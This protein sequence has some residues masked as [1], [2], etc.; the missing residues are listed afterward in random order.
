MFA[1][2]PALFASG[3]PHVCS[4]GP[5]WVADTAPAAATMTA[6]AWGL[7]GGA[8]GTWVIIN[9]ATA[10]VYVSTDNGANFVTATSG[11]FGTIRRAIAYGNS[12]FLMANGNTDA[13]TSPDGL[14]WTVHP[15][16]VFGCSLLKF[17]PLF[18]L[19]FQV[20][21]FDGSIYST[22][23]GITFTP[24]ANPMSS[25]A[26]GAMAVTS[27][28][29][30]LVTTDQQSCSTVNGSTWLAGGALPFATVGDNNSAM[31]FG[32]GALVIA[33]SG[34][35]NQIAR[36][37]NNGASWAL[38]GLLPVAGDWFT[39]LFSNG[40]HILM[41]LLSSQVCISLDGGVTWGLAAN[42]GVIA[43]LAGAV[44]DQGHYIAT[45][46]SATNAIELGTC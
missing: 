9:T 23:D 12:I 46:S 41:D 16:G 27:T 1:C 15:H 34:N 5:A 6:V 14:I 26:Y 32:N 8:D 10:S 25:N 24:V 4:T 28:A 13:N 29:V 18:N 3:G 21:I 39:C 31:A 44:S 38:G 2:G 22:P 36:S 33:R 30:V 45:G 35:T 19:F 17:H 40:A 20:G 42:Q 43:A 11:T 7:T 37:T